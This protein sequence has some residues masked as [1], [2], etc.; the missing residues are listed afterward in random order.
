MV[1]LGGLATPAIA[2]KS[3]EELE[4][5]SAGFGA[6]VVLGGPV[7]GVCSVHGS[8]WVLRRSMCVAPWVLVLITIVLAVTSG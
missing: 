3:A 6:G 5:A 8:S 4:Q 1:L 7:T 2:E